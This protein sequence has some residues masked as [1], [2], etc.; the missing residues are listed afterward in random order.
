MVAAVFCALAY[1]SVYVFH[2]KVA[3][4]TFDAKDAVIGLASLLLGP[5]YGIVSAALVAVLEFITISDTGVYGLIMNF[6]STGTFALCCGIIYKYKRTF[7]GAI[8]AVIMSLISVTAVMMLANLFIT[9]FFMGA[10]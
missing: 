1:A 4:L 2:I 6:L 8:L 5:V 9:P 3:F 10:D 7:P